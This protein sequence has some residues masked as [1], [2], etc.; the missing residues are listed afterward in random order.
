MTE[1]FEIA[2]ILGQIAFLLLGTIEG[3]KKNY[4]EATYYLVFSLALNP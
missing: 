2:A 1:V 3:F 4:S